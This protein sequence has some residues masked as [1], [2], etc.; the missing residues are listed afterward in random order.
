MLKLPAVATAAVLLFS[1]SPQSAIAQTAE[2]TIP[3]NVRLFIP[4]KDYSP[5]DNKRIISRG[6]L[7]VASRRGRVRWGWVGNET[8][9]ML[10]PS[11][12]DVERSGRTRG[13]VHT[14]KQVGIAVTARYVPSKPT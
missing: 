13:P 3:D 14:Q 5:D 2:T 1:A 8:A 4:Y 12:P 10:E 9:K 11:H 7:P 6:M